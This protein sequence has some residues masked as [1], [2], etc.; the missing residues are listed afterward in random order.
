MPNTSAHQ[1]TKTTAPFGSWAS[2]ISSNDLVSQA[3]R[4]GEPLLDGDDIYWIEGRPQEQGRGVLLKRAFNDSNAEGTEVLPNNCN[5][6]SRAHEYGGASY[7]VAQGVVY[8]VEAGD[9]RIYRFDPKRDN[10]PTALSPEGHF[11]YA[12]LFVDTLR[13]R[14]LCVRED[15][16]AKQAA[17]DQPQGHQ[18]TEETNELVSLACTAP[19]EPQVIA[20][21]CDFYSNPRLSPDGKKLSWLSWNHPCMPWDSSQCW[22]AALDQDGL[23]QSTICVAGGDGDESI[24]QPQWS[25]SGELF[26]VSDR[27]NWWNIYRYCA[28]SDNLEVITQTQSEFA[29][30]QWVFGMSCYG[31]V[32]NDQILACHSQNG[33]W[34]LAGINTTSKKITHIN[35]PYCDISALHC[36]PQRAV[37]LAAGATSFS[38]LIS[39]ELTNLDAANV[40]LELKVVAQSAD[41]KLDANDISVAQPI[42]FDSARFITDI[43]NGPSQ[44]HGFYYPPTN[45]HFDAPSGETPPLIVLGHGGP[46]GAT[47]TGLNFKI[48]YWS[49][50][51]FA[52]MDVNY[53]GSTGYGRDYRQ[54]LHKQWGVKD[55]EDVCAAAD[56]LIEQG[57]ADPERVTIKGSSAGGYT[58][59]A[60]LTFRDT[61]KAGTSLYG[62]GDLETLASDTHKFE[63]RYLDSLVGAYP[64]QQALYQARSPIHHAKQ[65]NCPVIFFQGLDDKVVPPAQAESMVAILDGKQVPVAYVPFKGEGHGFRQ[66]FAIAR[67]IDAELSFYA[68]VFGFPL[69]EQDQTI[70]PVTVKNLCPASTVNGDRH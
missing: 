30:P 70:E 15:H 44:A 53:R 69:S 48:Q 34:Q 9:Q 31:F 61:F 23:C 52:V 8:F 66:A 16:R 67:A 10:K 18:H 40:D 68:Q 62:I 47:E 49:S 26:L 20:S 1:P 28:S 54:Q 46:T 59:L 39:L 24:F 11:R 17:S 21:G 51:G 36:D 38:S 6:R 4:L 29:T 58:V 35:N 5:V 3:V 14:I 42:S 13:Q 19:S 64:E 12:D 55:V 56:Y 45:Q 50:R 60:A 27:D 43:S 32:A 65:L 22:L 25:P 57:L 33:R 37:I 63:A 41:S 7:T 2:P